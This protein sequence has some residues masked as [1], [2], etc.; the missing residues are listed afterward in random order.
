MDKNILKPVD[1]FQNL[2]LMENILRFC[3]LKQELSILNL[4]NISDKITI[5]SFLIQAFGVSF[6]RNSE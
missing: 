3:L 1:L 4:F 6:N 2:L 5:C